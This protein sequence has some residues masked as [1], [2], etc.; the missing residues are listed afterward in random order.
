LGALSF[1]YCARAIQAVLD[2]QHSKGCLMRKAIFVTLA[3]LAATMLSGCYYMDGDMGNSALDKGQAIKT[4]WTTTGSFTAI[5][6]SGPDKIIFETGDVFRIKA[7]GNAEILK[8]LRFL[9]R[10][11]KIVIG[12]KSGSGYGNSEAATITVTA[13]TLNAIELAGSGGI[14]ADQLTG[15]KAKLS[16]AGSGY[17]D[18]AAVNAEALDAEI[19]GSGRLKLSGKS[20]VVDYSI[21]GSGGLDAEELES[22]TVK[23]SIA[24]SGDAKLRA[25]TSVS[26]DISG[27]GTVKVTGGAKCTS[28]VAGS[29]SLD[30][31]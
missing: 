2:Q 4:D 9:V 17:A 22:N 20:A 6:G 31:T 26:A 3:P 10:D 24:G 19:A 18:V 29:G 12:R 21:A 7:A 13:P 25:T 11:G 30:C 1:W 8:K 16:I 23:I 15:K 14:N 28:S 5:D 27:S